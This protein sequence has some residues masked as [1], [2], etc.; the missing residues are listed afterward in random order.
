MLLIAVEHGFNEIFS[1]HKSMWTITNYF[2]LNLTIADIMMAMF[3]C[4]PSFIYMRD[5][6]LNY[7][8][9]QIFFLVVVTYL[10][11]AVKI[12]NVHILGHWAKLAYPTP[13]I[14]NLGHGIIRTSELFL[15]PPSPIGNKDMEV[16]SQ[17]NKKL[18][19][20]G[21]YTSNSRA[22]KY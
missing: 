19:S 13:P 5:R 12:K 3:N 7:N 2:L 22:S 10:R 1:A 16:Y 18:Q 14:G 15:D 6:Y 21:K 17:C 8:I 9:S 4:I 11:R 20:K